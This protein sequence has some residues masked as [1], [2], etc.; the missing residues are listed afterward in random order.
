MLIRHRFESEDAE[1]AKSATPA[2]DCRTASAGGVAQ[3]MAAALA[4]LGELPEARSEAQAGLRIVPNFTV[5][6]F[7]ADPLMDYPALATI[8]LSRC[9]AGDAG[10]CVRPAGAK[11][12]RRATRPA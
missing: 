5:A 4:R 12:W 6:R 7:R 11:H 9:E 3:Q 2:G 10:A 1:D 8:W